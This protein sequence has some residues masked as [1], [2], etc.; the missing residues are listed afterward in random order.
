MTTL[1]PRIHR[2]LTDVNYGR[3]EFID[4]CV[5]RILKDENIYLLSTGG[6][7]A[8]KDLPPV[9]AEKYRLLNKGSEMVFIP[10]FLGIMED[11]LNALSSATKPMCG[12]V[13]Y[14][15]PIEA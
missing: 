12:K 7:F 4:D 8:C 14:A 10:G 15:N 3:E 5:Q 2:P 11:V 9:L 6:Y 1:K 13:H